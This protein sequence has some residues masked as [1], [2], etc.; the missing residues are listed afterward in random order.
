MSDDGSDDTLIKNRKCSP[1]KLILKSK[2]SHA[3]RSVISIANSD[4]TVTTP[5]NH[6]KGSASVSHGSPCARDF[7]C[8]RRPSINQAHK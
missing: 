6:Y 7:E 5:G 2:L 3:A 8:H 1:Q 4:R